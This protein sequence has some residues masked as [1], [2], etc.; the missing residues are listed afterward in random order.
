MSKWFEADKDGLRQIAERLVEARGFGI[1]LAELY[2]N[3]M[4]TNATECSVE[5]EKVPG[6][7]LAELRVTD[8]DP[9][10]FADLTHAYTLY[11]PSGK[12]A[13][14]S[15]AGRF[16]LGEKYVLAFCQTAN[17]TTTTGCI[18][19]GPDG[20][21]HLPRRKTNVGTAFEA[22]IDC[23]TAQMEQMAQFARRLI[24]KPGLRL[25]VNGEEVPHRKPFTSFTAKLPTEIS[26]DAGNLTRT[27]RVAEVELYEPLAGEV[28]MLYELGIPVVETGDKWHYNVQ[29]KVPLNTERDNVTPKY[30]A[31]LR[32]F[33][34]NHTHAMLGGD[35]TEAEWVN[36]A[37]GNDKAAPA[38]VETFR[39]QK[40]GEKSVAEDPFN[41]EANAEAVAHGYTVIP[42][43]GLTPGQRANLKA[44]NFLL[45]SSAAFPTAGKGVYSDDP[46]AEPVE[47]IGPDRQTAPMTEVARYTEE[48]AHRL[49]GKKVTVVFVKVP[50]RQ[51]AQPWLAC[52]GRGHLLGRSEFHFNVGVLGQ[53]W[54]DNRVTDKVDELIIHEF[55]HEYNPNHLAAEYHA[56]LCKLGA[57]LVQAVLDDPAWFKKWRG[58]A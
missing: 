1:I 41:A 26:N 19:F 39:V 56:G 10:G 52:Y 11:A 48:L 2:Q 22:V 5:F 28:P 21:E 36:V 4:D 23:T 35:D 24:V 18:S 13:D 25:M 33:V 38:A 34:F 49:M 43:H 16:N 32:T 6:R 14:P 7:P 40:F 57:R 8:N 46:D 54:F 55:G 20:R 37:A 3:V 12:K 29:Q 30:L 15:K 50:P 45:S 27:V 58:R 53:R 31:D 47:V 9:N 17:I 51:C 44:N 42:K